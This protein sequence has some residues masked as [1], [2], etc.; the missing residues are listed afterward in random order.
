MKKNREGGFTLIGLLIFVAMIGLFSAI[1]LPAYQ[2]YTRVHE[3]ISKMLQSAEEVQ[4]VIENA[5]RSTGTLTGSGSE[6]SVSVYPMFE[7]YVSDISVGDDGVITISGNSNTLG[8]NNDTELTLVPNL[9]LGVV[10]WKCTISNDVKSFT[11]DKCR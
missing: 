9:H 11:P 3:N 4:A 7:P 8:I 5:V 2:D 1:V 10:V 6:M